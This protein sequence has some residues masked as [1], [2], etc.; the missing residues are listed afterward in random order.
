MKYLNQASYGAKVAVSMLN[1][2]SMKML[3][4]ALKLL[5]ISLLSSVTLSLN[6]SEFT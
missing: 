6:N 1:C 5:F 2:M 4:S 3:L